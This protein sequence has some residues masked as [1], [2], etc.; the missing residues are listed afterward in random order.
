MNHLEMNPTINPTAAGPLAP[1]A[2]MATGPV[3]SIDIP[4]VGSIPTSPDE[5]I[6][7]VGQTTQTIFS[8]VMGPVAELVVTGIITTAGVALITYAVIR[9]T[10]SSKLVEHVN[11]QAAKVVGAVAKV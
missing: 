6:D 10:Q 7:A 4:G 2:S 9:A 5:I 11:D 3:A 1:L 8:A